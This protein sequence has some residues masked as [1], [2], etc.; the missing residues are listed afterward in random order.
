MTSILI[1]VNSVAVMIIFKYKDHLLTGQKKE[2]QSQMEIEVII[3]SNVFVAIITTILVY[4]KS[5]IN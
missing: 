3:I 4:H 1:N 5:R 2:A